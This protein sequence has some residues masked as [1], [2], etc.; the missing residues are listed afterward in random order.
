MGHKCFISYKKEDQAYRDELDN[1]LESADVIN[2][3]LDRTID[4]DD[5]DYIMRTIRQEYLKDSTVTI[6]LIGTHSS[7]YEGYDSNGQRKNYFIEH[8][9]QASLYDG[10]GNTRNGVL[11]VT[12]PEMD[13]KIWGGLYQ[14]RICGNTHRF[15]HV[16]DATVIREFHMNYYIE[17]HSGCAWSEDERYCVLVSWEKFIINPT[18]WIDCAYNKRESAIAEKVKVRNFR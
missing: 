5:G 12:L 11:G 16:A 1:V 9:L 7:E 17:P 15:V 8:E 10:E 14:C 18:Y 6:V 3:G 2:K 4:S 13:S